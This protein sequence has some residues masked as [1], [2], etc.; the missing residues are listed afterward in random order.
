MRINPNQSEKPF[1]SG[2]LKNALKLIR[3][4]PIQSETSIRMNPNESEVNFQS[5]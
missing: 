5:K 2:L 1:K 4:N 3:L